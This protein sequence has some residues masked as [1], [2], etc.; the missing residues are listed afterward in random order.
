MKNADNIRCERIVNSALMNDDR[1]FWVEVKKINDKNCS[2]SIVLRAMDQ[3]L[4]KS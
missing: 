1:N 2:F 4:Q 3:K